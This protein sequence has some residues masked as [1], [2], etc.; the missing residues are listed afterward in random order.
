MD[1]Q[2][3]VV[4]IRGDLAIQLVGQGHLGERFPALEAHRVVRSSVGEEPGGD[5]TSI[6][7][8]RSMWAGTVDGSRKVEEEFLWGVPEGWLLPTPR[9]WSAA[10]GRSIQLLRR[11]P[12]RTG[13]SSVGR[14]TA[15]LR[16]DMKIATSNTMSDTPAMTNRHP[17]SWRAITA[18]RTSSE[19]RFITLISGLRAVRPCP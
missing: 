6:D 14:S 17:L 12:D 7:P 1:D 5:G 9:K 15:P 11:P 16:F 8:P 18:G 3:H 4:P 10:E 13:S 19:T 2:H